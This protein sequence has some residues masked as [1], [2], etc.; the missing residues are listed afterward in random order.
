MGSRVGTLPEI[1]AD[2]T[3]PLGDRVR[4]R[5][6]ESSII[7]QLRGSLREI[8]D[9]WGVSKEAMA[10]IAPESWLEWGLGA[11]GDQA[12]T[13]PEADILAAHDAVTANST[14]AQQKLGKF[15]QP[16][17]VCCLHI[18]ARPAAGDVTP[19]GTWRSAW[20]VRDEGARQGSLQEPPRGRSYRMP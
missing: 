9:T 8:R 15:G 4:R 19:A 10:G 14:K 13:T 6:P 3:G 2:L 7:T 11:E 5:L 18:L 17:Q 16:G 20:K 12:P 1:L